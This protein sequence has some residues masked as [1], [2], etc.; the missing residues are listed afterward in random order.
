MS[1]SL[2]ITFKAGRCVID[3]SVYFSELFVFHI[4]T[5][6]CY[7][8]DSGKPYKVTP[9]PTPG[10]IYLYTEDGEYF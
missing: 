2:L 1:K 4:Y 9:D 5:C 8:Q 10:Y 3:V 6:L 7:K